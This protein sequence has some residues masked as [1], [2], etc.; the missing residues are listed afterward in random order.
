LLAGLLFGRHFL[1][2]GRGDFIGETIRA[3]FQGKITIYQESNRLCEDRKVPIQLRGLSFSCFHL[4]FAMI[5]CYLCIVNKI[6]ERDD[7]E[8]YRRFCQEP[9]SQ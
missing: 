4:Y 2:Q 1:K 8:Y 7:D 9:F 3:S 5:L 6:E